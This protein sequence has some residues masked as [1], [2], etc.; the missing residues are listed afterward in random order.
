MSDDLFTKDEAEIVKRMTR[1]RVSGEFL[2]LNREV[3]AELEHNVFSQFAALNPLDYQKF[4]SNMYLVLSL[5]VR[6][7]RDFVALLNSAV[8]DGDY[9]ENELRSLN[10]NGSK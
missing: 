5:K 1:G 9:A 8:S 4:D 6:V 7:I 3:L 10:K 2:A